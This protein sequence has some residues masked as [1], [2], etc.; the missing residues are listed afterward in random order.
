[1]FLIKK[2]VGGNQAVIGRLGW[3]LADVVFYFSI[4]TGKLENQETNTK[5][6]LVFFK[7]L[8]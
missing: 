1:M 8:S 3:G 2:A 7:D 4:Y 6:G 5:T